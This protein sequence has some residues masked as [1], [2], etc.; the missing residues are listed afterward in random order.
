[1]G[2]SWTRDQTDVPCVARQILNHWTTRAAWNHPWQF[3]AS[4]HRR[5]REGSPY[6]HLPNWRLL[7]VIVKC[8]DDLRQELLAFQVL[9]Q[10]QVRE[11]G[12]KERK[13]SP[14]V[15]HLRWS[16]RSF[17]WKLCWGP[18]SCLGRSWISIKLSWCLSPEVKPQE[19]LHSALLWPFCDWHLF[20]SHI[21]KLPT[22]LQQVVCRGLRCQSLTPQGGC[23]QAN[24][25]V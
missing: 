5:I 13:P 19:Q 3:F 22:D 7:S 9:K 11:V 24:S 17:C 12:E 21:K 23:L 25:P 20:W 16:H 1:M 18:T 10:L 4:L 6:G 2:S 14:S 15:A 8:G